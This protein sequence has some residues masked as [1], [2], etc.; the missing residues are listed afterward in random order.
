MCAASIFV[1]VPE[2]WV[3]TFI[4]IISYFLPNYMAS[5]LEDR[6]FS[7]SHHDKLRSHAIK[8]FRGVEDF[9]QNVGLYENAVIVPC[10]NHST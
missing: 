7:I 1:F 6:N 4:R 5:N 2:V 3:S 9:G 10:S 8:V